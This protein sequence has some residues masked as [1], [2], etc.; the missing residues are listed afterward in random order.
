MR[1]IYTMVR[2]DDGLMHFVLDAADAGDHDGDGIEDQSD[3]WEV[4]SQTDPAM[5]VALGDGRTP[6]HASATSE[7]ASDKWGDFMTGWA[8]LLIAMAGST[9]S[10][11]WTWKPVGMSRT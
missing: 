6:G 10:S 5:P 9:A 11:A 8:P 7:P 4:Y 2:G 1:Y 3:V